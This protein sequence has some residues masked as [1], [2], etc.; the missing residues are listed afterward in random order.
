MLSQ[1]EAIGGWPSILLVVGAGCAVA[2]TLLLTVPYPRR[3][4]YYARQATD[5]LMFEKP[6]KVV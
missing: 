1:T 2:L 6:L 4:E 5:A 3:P